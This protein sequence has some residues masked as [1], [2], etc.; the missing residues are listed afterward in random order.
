MRKHAIQNKRGLIKH[1]NVNVNKLYK[2]NKLYS[3]NYHHKK[4]RDCYILHTFLLVIIL[5]TL[6]TF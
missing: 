5:V 6:T 3:I 1:V 4:V 2:F